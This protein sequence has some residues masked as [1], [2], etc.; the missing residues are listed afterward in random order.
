M[1]Q[2]V[3]PIKG[4]IDKLDF[5]KIKSF[6]SVNT[7]LGWKDKLKFGEKIFANY[8]SDKGLVSRKYREHSSL[9]KKYPQN[10]NFNRVKKYEGDFTEGNIEMANTWKDVHPLEKC[11]SKPQWDITIHL[12]GWVK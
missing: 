4:K 10:S 7:L 11:I 6:A 8:V 1:I 5:N 2:N 3:L 12:S 9:S